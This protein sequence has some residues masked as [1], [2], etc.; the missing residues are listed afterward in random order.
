LAAFNKSEHYG[1]FYHWGDGSG[2]GTL[3]GIQLLAVLFIFS[4][5][6]VI[7]GVYFY[8]LNLLGW[9]RIDP[10]EEEVGMDIR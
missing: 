1:W 5:T 2:D 10:L 8:C 4:W 7:M 9:L 6:F 3:L